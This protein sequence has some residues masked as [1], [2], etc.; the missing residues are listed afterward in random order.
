MR[1]TDNSNSN[2]GEICD[3]DTTSSRRGFLKSGATIAAAGAAA[4]LL[5]VAATAQGAGDADP[6]LRALQGQRRILIK[7]G[8]V[9]SL[10][11]QVGDFAQ[12]DVLIEDG[13][14]REV[15]PNI[16]ASA[17]SAAVVDAANRIVIPG[18]IDSHHHF[19]QGILRNI[20]TNGLLNPDYNRDIS[21]TLTAVYQ[22]MDVYAGEL[23]TALGMIDMGTTTAVDTSQVQHSPEHTDASIRALQESGLRVVY[24]YSRGAGAATRYPQD[25]VR[26]QRTTFSSKDQLLTLALGGTLDAKIFAYAREV[27]VPTV[28]HGVNNATERT[29][30]ELGQMGLLRPGDEY[31]HCTHLSDA[32]WRLI[33]D[34]G[35]RVSLSPPIEMAMGHGLPG[36]QDAL[37]HGLRPSLSSDVDVTMAQDPFTVMRSAFTLQRLI[38]LQRARGGAQNLPPLVTCR[39]VLEF[40]TIEGARCALLDHKTGTLTPG[41]EADIV[42]LRA[43]RLNVWPLNNVP[44]AVVNLMNPGHVESVF[45]AGKPRKWRGNLVGV[46][47]PRVLRLVEEARDGVIRRANFRANLFG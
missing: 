1:D 40:A 39:E 15:R 21:N 26:L 24:A 22:P 20:L 13:R 42:L 38:L 9:L 46:D 35:G 8:I 32:A 23:V 43:D 47:T 19:Y 36:I 10:D 7:G 30:F 31:I 27:G 44:G 2:A 34:T 17:E 33:K 29:L 25:I 16:A 28:S 6:E 3:L 37:D 5:P 45:I 41:K 18:F 4:Q 14:I 12:G 11:R